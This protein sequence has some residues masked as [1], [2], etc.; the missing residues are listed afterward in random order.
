MKN[1]LRL[2]IIFLFSLFFISLF[3]LTPQDIT[4]DGAYYNYLAINYNLKEMVPFPYHLLFHLFE[5]LLA[6]TFYSFYRIMPFSI[7]RFI[8]SIAL[9]IDSFLLY[10]LSTSIGASKKIAFITSLIFPLSYT[11]WM[12]GMDGDVYLI[13]LIPII[14]GYILIL[15]ERVKTT[16]NFILVS[17][18]T[19]LS[20]LL[21]LISTVGVTLLG[22][23]LLIRCFKKEYP[24]SRFLIFLFTNIFICSITYTLIGKLIVRIDSIHNF[25]GWIG[26]YN[27]SWAPM[28][29]NKFFLPLIGFV[30]FF[31]NGTL[32]TNL[33]YNEPFTFYNILSAI[34]FFF[35]ALFLICILILMVLNYKKALSFRKKTVIFL[36][37]SIIAYFLFNS[38]W[39][40]QY[41]PYHTF[42]MIFILPLL[43]IIISKSSSK[44]LYKI[45]ITFILFITLINLFFE[46]I[47]RS[48]FFKES[49]LQWTEDEA[50]IKLNISDKDAIICFDFVKFPLFYYT[51][52]ESNPKEILIRGDQ[53]SKGNDNEIKERFVIYEKMLKE[54]L[55]N[56]GKIYI[57]GTVIDCK[58]FRFDIYK[59][60][61]Y[62]SGQLIRKYWGK[63]IKETP[64]SFTYRGTIYKMYYIEK[65]D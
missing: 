53:M 4:L 43:S 41:S 13:A 26:T 39:V 6:I 60:S 22:I 55:N 35:T 63:H 62:P 17:L 45:T 20:V 11:P 30:R 50:L 56:D 37:S 36:T 44:L 8:N 14:F 59:Y 7:I 27:I 24:I 23:Y 34:L 12:L 49:P 61:P 33:L 28:S 2:L 57:S 47:P 58:P 64:M 3:I 15:Q 29:I 65:F 5:K 46:I 32:F 48:R 54:I 40:P 21:H 10:R 19:S 51:S 42:T 9:I 38:K 18:L 52:G 25:L 1:K 31:F 16:R